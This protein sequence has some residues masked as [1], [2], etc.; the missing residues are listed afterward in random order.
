[1]H[2]KHRNLL[3]ETRGIGLSGQMLGPVLIDSW[4]RPLPD[5]AERWGVPKEI[6]IAVGAG[7]NVGD[8]SESGLGIPATLLFRWEHL[9]FIGGRLP[10]PSMG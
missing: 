4:N 3:T 9:Q 7:D 1:L 8:R 10:Q 5:L 6:A 2:A